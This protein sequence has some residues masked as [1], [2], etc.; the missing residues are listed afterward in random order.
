[1][2]KT[3][4]KKWQELPIGGLIIEPGN[5]VEYES[6]SWSPQTLIFYPDRC[7]Q[8]LQCWVYCPDASIEVKD[9]KM[10]GIDHYHCKSCGICIE[11]C[12]TEPKSL[13]LSREEESL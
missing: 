2:K 6:G 1:M 8:C 11:H 3:T 13:E 12:P 7:I 4:L 10:T 9:G 5:S